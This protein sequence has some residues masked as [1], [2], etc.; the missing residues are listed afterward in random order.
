LSS[1]F[2][3]LRLQSRREDKHGIDFKA[4]KNNKV[5]TLPIGRDLVDALKTYKVEQNRRRLRFGAGYK[6]LGLIVANHDG[7]PRDPNAFTSTFRKVVKDAGLDD[8]GPHVLRHKWPSRSTCIAMSALRCRKRPPTKLRRRSAPRSLR[9]ADEEGPKLAWPVAFF[10]PW[11][12]WWDAAGQ[13]VRQTFI[14]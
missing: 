2:Q 13:E 11:D 1:P 6:D 14:K 9:Q 4:P 3:K 7:S 12:E 10:N 5:R 8:M